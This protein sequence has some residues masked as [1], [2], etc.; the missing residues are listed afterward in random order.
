MPRSVLITKEKIL[1]AAL[2]ILIRDGYSAVNIKSIAKELKCS[3]Q[4]IVWQFGSMEN[5]REALTQ[6]AVA[7]ANRKMTPT[8]ENCMEAFWQIGRA[9]IDLAFDVPNLFRFVYMGESRYYC[10]GGSSSI[11]TDKGNAALIDRL[12]PY[13]GIDRQKAEKLLQRII[14]YTH[15]IVSLV[16]SG[17]L[18]CTKEQVNHLVREFGA[19]QLSFTGTNLDIAAIMRNIDTG[20]L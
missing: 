13:L 17:V 5:M 14:V 15:G 20:A 7:Y 2:D 8:S 18:N 10:R 19:E 1:T 16:V 12:C 9:Y 3:T 6:E 11:L 4:P